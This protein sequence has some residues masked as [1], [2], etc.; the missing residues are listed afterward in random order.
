M[1]TILLTGATGF[2]G[3]YLAEALCPGNNIIVLKR[4]FSKT[5]RMTNILPRVK[6]YDIDRLPI[7]N[8]F[9]ENKID[10]VI[11]AATN[12]GRGTAGLSEVMEANLYFPTRVLECCINHRMPIFINTD[13]VV[14]RD[15]ND[16][17]LAKKQFLE[18]LQ[19]YQ[20]SVQVINLK[21]EH[22]YGPKDDINKFVTR[23]IQKVLKDEVIDLTA[24]E[25]R[26]DFIYIEDVVSAYMHVIE[27]LSNIPKTCFEAEVG[28]G[29]VI[30][31]K[32]LVETIKA[33][34]KS[35]SIL[36]FGAVPYRDNEVMESQADISGMLQLGWKP[37]ISLAEGLK[38]TIEYERSLLCCAKNS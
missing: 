36:N 5:D 35:K 2:L 30:S 10:M 24:G 9:V 32:E 29:K 26:R 33:I 22:F 1:K 19:R 31:I 27:Q 21:L 7:E 38:R 23:V 16:Y 13:T 4:S 6:C 12:Y 15:L 8:A 14:G 25:Q 20:G 37:S 11:H 18:W 3:S 17:A 28:S 34:A